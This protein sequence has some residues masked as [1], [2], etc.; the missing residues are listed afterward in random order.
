VQAAAAG[1]LRLRRRLE[2]A[3]AERFAGAPVKPGWIALRDDAGAREWHQGEY[4]GTATGIEGSLVY[5]CRRDCANASPAAATPTSSSTS[6]RDATPSG[7]RANCPGP[8]GRS[9]SEFLR[10]QAGIDGVRAGLLR[11]LRPEA[12]SLPCRRCARDQGRAA[13]PAARAPAR[14]GDQ[15]RGRRRARGAG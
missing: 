8:R 14:R 5:A 12:A 11:E 2:P 6:R 1:E 3:F 9:F 4:R 7:S 15:Q 10:R 13:A